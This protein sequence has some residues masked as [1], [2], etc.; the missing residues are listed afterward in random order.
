MNP[1]QHLNNL[2][3]PSSQFLVLTISSDSQGLSKHSNSSEVLMLELVQK[4][5]DSD[6][7]R[8]IKVPTESSSALAVK[9]KEELPSNAY[10]VACKSLIQARSSLGAGEKEEALEKAR[11]AVK[12]F[13]NIIKKDEWS[14]EVYDYMLD[15]QKIASEAELGIQ[16]R[17]ERSKQVRIYIHACSHVLVCMYVCMCVCVCVYIYIYIYMR[18]HA[19]LQTNIHQRLCMHVCVCVCVCIYI[20]IYLQTYTNTN[21]Q[22]EREIAQ[23]ITMETHQCIHTLYTHTHTHTRTERSGT[24]DCH[25]A[26]RAAQGPR[27]KD[28]VQELRQRSCG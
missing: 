6:S 16:E 25:G 19:H 27:G 2:F 26:A 4:F 21:T 24:K 7:G 10:E 8:D 11:F 28:Q 13:E 18:T 15:A 12:L 14:V 9:P 17:D 22:R 3:L 20:F 23:K 5:S 1:A